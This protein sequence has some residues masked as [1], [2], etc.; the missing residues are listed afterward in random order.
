MDDQRFPRAI[1]LICPFGLANGGSAQRR[2]GSN[3]GIILPGRNRGNIIPA[4][5]FGNYGV[6]FPAA[7]FLFRGRF[8]K[9][10]KGEIIFNDP[11]RVP[12]E[13]LV[14]VIDRLRGG[15]PRLIRMNNEMRVI[16]FGTFFLSSGLSGSTPG[17]VPRGTL[18]RI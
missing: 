8:L 12:P 6:F 18:E 4:A 10:G 15:C 7:A 16:Q 17:S 2:V 11:G 5:V 1:P 14:D 13:S 3:V 9:K